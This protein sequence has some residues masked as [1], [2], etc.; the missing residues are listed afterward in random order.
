MKVGD[1]IICKKDHGNFYKDKQY[2][3]TE[4]V[5]VPSNDPRKFRITI[6]NFYMSP[7]VRNIMPTK[8]GIS[9]YFFDHGLCHRQDFPGFYIWDYFYTKKEI[10]KEKIKKI[11]ETSNLH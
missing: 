9:V 8:N 10:R 1:K 4:V 5:N 3:I 2:Y 6:S 7:N 11:N